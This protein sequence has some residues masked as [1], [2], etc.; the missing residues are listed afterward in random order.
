MNASLSAINISPFAAT[1]SPLGSTNEPPEETIVCAP[2]AGFTRIIA[3][4]PPNAC[5]SPTSKLPSEVIAMPIGS[6]KLPA[7]EITVGWPVIGPPCK[8]LL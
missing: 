3:P 4:D 1:A 6:S 2:F 5:W 7:E 8:L